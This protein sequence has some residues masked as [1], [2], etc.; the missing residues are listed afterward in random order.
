MS[1]AG[2]RTADVEAEAQAG[3]PH[4]LVVDDDPVMRD[5]VSEYLAKNDLKVTAAAAAMRALLGKEVMDVVR[6]LRVESASPIVM[7]G[8]RSEEADRVMRS[9]GPGCG[10]SIRK[11]VHQA[12]VCARRVALWSRPAAASV[13]SATWEP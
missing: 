1:L 10:R 7:L 12:P 9:R 4:I 3:H 6:R 8:G 11:R 5:L 13:T 2:S